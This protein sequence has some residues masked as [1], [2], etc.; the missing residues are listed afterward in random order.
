MM[1]IMETL[2]RMRIQSGSLWVVHSP[3][4]ELLLCFV[5]YGST[6]LRTCH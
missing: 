2:G 1:V 3:V 6:A 5:V 4:R